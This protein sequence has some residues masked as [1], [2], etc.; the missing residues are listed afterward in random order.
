MN[1]IY[2]QIR[3]ISRTHRLALPVSES[4]S[5]E[6]DRL[7]GESARLFLKALRRRDMLGDL[8]RVSAEQVKEL[9]IA[10]RDEIKKIEDIVQHPPPFGPI[11]KDD[12]KPK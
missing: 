12:K 6:R 7:R 10:K 5:S 11:H 1:V 8:S 3:M 2:N 4:N 9:L